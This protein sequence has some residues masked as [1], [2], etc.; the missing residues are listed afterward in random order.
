MTEERDDVEERRLEALAMRSSGVVPARLAALLGDDDWRVRKQAAETAS[1][2]LSSDSVL[3]LLAT[4]VL[5]P[6]DVGLR[7]ACVEAFARAPRADAPRV[8]AVL[9]DALARG[10]RTTR[11]FV[12]AA[13]VGG[14]EGAIEPLAQ[15]V[16]DDDVMT[17]SCAVEALAALARR[18]VEGRT[19]AAVLIETL[20][21]GEPVLRLAAL[22][23]LA[24]IGASVEATVLAPLL[25]EPITR[26]SALRLLARARGGSERGGPD[27]VT[28][29]LLGTLPHA[30]S[31]V[32]AALALA[33]R[34]DPERPPERRAFVAP[35]SRALLI[36]T[37]A[38]LGPAA[39]AEFARA[40][41]ERPLPE[42]RALA[43]LALEAEELRLLPAIVSLGARA[44]LDPACREAL[45]A[46]GVRVVSPLL[47]IA[48]E[49]AADDVRGA[50]WAL[51]V[52]TDLC[53]LSDD[54]VRFQL[55]LLSVA[56]QLLAQ[57]EEVGARAAAA[58]LGRYGDPDDARALA[59]RVGAYGTAFEATAAQAVEAIA[60]RASIE[61]RRAMPERVGRRSLSSS[62][63]IALPDLR[64][65]LASE[66]P[67]VRARGLD[68]VAIGGADE[69]ELAAL[70]LTDEDERVE[71]A[72]LRALTRVR[73]PEL[74]DA[75]IAAVTIAT[76]SELPTVR[77]EAIQTLSQLGAFGTHAHLE[78]LVSAL[79]DASPRVVIAAL[80]AL[81]SVRPD[82]PRLERALERAVAH[83]DAEV[84]KEALFALPEASVVAHAGAALHH[85]H[86]SVRARA[87][88]VLARASALSG[89][90]E[91]AEIRRL[92]EARRP[93]ESDELVQRAIGG[94]LAG[95]GG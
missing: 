57:G 73:G 45:V 19:V 32:E 35:A 20:R 38:S 1:D 24:A 95:E 81:G 26:P 27:E 74:T 6:D 40:L 89:A 17:A 8:A 9:R 76:T 34:S 23:G 11:K 3:E 62:G 71:L 53:A 94:V 25:A 68:D 52:A 83:V 65:Q 30:R 18:G 56:R 13:L 21:R 61:A 92:L 44:E 72:A 5:A 29:L 48:R 59:A 69:L 10:P 41:A 79:E 86:W 15:L 37:S 16:R 4:G 49:T 33:E 47:E 2:L 91:R 50:S 77:A 55:E 43:R 88:E 60:S 82:D 31:T 84:V 7:N 64:A 87:V 12:A 78:R 80:R 46:L 51:E 22:D 14:G 63:M 54:G 66:D 58:T 90:R 67:D 36:S 28:A 93:E 75:A 85:E 70:A 42:A 39:I